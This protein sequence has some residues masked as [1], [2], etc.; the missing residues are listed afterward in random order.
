MRWICILLDVKK[1]KAQNDLH[2][3]SPMYAVYVH[4]I[5]IYIHI[6]LHVDGGHLKR[7]FLYPVMG[8]R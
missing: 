2:I 5:P 6:N 3:T 1:R 8:K 4:Y 7:L